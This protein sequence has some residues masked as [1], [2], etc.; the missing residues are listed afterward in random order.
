M[1]G[2]FRTNDHF[3]RGPFSVQT[4]LLAGLSLIDRKGFAENFLVP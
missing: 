4:A 1:G 2:I 3:D